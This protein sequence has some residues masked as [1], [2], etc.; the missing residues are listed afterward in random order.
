MCDRKASRSKMH[1]AFTEVGF[2][3]TVEEEAGL[4]ATEHEREVTKARQ[5]IEDLKKT[6]AEQQRTV[7]KLANENARLVKQVDLL[8]QS[9]PVKGKDGLNG[10]LEIQVLRNAL[11]QCTREKQML[12]NELHRERQKA[13]AHQTGQPGHSEDQ[14]HLIAVLKESLDEKTQQVAVLTV[15]LEDARAE[16][17]ASYAARHS[18]H[19]GSSERLDRDMSVD[20]SREV[21]NLK[22][23]NA[24]LEMEVLAL[25]RE[26]TEVNSECVRLKEYSLRLQ[27]DKD[28]LVKQVEAKESQAQLS[29]E[30]LGVQM[31]EAVMQKTAKI[32]E[33]LDYAEELQDTLTTL[34]KEKDLLSTSLK[35]EAEYTRQLEEEKESIEGQL[36]E[37]NAKFQALEQ[38]LQRIS[39]M[40]DILEASQRE[41][42]NVRG[43]LEA[44]L[45]SVSQERDELVSTVN[46]LQEGLRSTCSE[47][48]QQSQQ[49]KLLS[50]TVT[51]LE[52]EKGILESQLATLKAELA[53]MESRFAVLQHEMGE[54]QESVK[55]RTQLEMDKVVS[56]LSANE[57]HTQHLQSEKDTL[58][59]RLKQFER[60]LTELTQEGDT[61][62]VIVREE[63]DVTMNKLNMATADL[64]K[65]QLTIEMLNTQVS[66]L[67]G[68][69]VDQKVQLDNLR[70]ELEESTE[71]ATYMSGKLSQKSTYASQLE[72]IIEQQ[73]GEIQRLNRTATQATLQVESSTP[74]S[75]SSTDRFRQSAR[76]S[77]SVDSTADRGD[78]GGLEISSIDAGEPCGPPPGEDV[79]TSTG[80]QGQSLLGHSRRSVSPNAEIASLRQRLGESQQVCIRHEAQVGSLKTELAKLQ[81]A[82]QALNTI[83]SHLTEQNQALQEANRTLEAER[84]AMQREREMVVVEMSRAR[85]TV[86]TL[87]TELSTVTQD[88]EELL[89][90]YRDTQTKVAE[91]EEK[92]IV[93]EEEVCALDDQR[94]AA[95]RELE[96]VAEEVNTMRQKVESHRESLSLCELE[97]E[98]L[99]HCILQEATLL[100]ECASEM[101]QNMSALKEDTLAVQEELQVAESINVAAS[102]QLEESE[103]NVS[104][105]LGEVEALR[106]KKSLM[107][108]YVTSQEQQREG[109]SQSFLAK[110]EEE[111]KAL[112]QRLQAHED[113]GMGQAELA[114]VLER[115][116]E[117]I[118]HLLGLLDEANREKA[119][120]Q[121]QLNSKDPPLKKEGEL[122]RLQRKVERMRVKLDVQSRQ[123]NYLRIKL[124]Y[125]LAE[126]RLYKRLKEEMA[127]QL[128]QQQAQI[129][130]SQEQYRQCVLKLELAGR[131]LNAS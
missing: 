54:V 48:E 38:E 78:V 100:S 91:L 60:Q 63:L 69:L 31:E 111:N 71:H 96:V 37:S 45:A 61:E 56:Q 98:S 116:D 8:W 12:M 127:S 81:G 55:H 107:L 44:D 117:E 41:A 121:E 22:Q 113:E 42:D 57:Q 84:D 33:L 64:E 14:S 87:S 30:E 129:L 46:A 3:Q 83:K 59:A 26:L 49:N 115:K 21:K 80:D 131:S 103:R 114:S 20:L 112:Q 73:K 23:T 28:G 76:H 128:E 122:S 89:A 104:V 29:I 5:E 118:S 92:L 77:T 62:L 123:V 51:Q 93:R 102:A 34:V 9:S 75:T 82:I 85:D 95:E 74:N 36:S 50:S 4:A 86:E 19:N 70:G 15:Q 7:G 126:L 65:Y 72:S 24:L 90:E 97:K 130:L 40:Q 35:Q 25:K 10:G 105:L 16:V 125:T 52:K 1:R 47:V 101:G 58:E 53:Q 66:D 88:K 27:E 17:V 6:N 124:G 39:E 119:G 106:A 68:Q 13:T 94:A 99:Q 120:L 18:S 11:E 110:L 67:E 108:Q 32:Q 109:Q 2:L 79:A 43:A